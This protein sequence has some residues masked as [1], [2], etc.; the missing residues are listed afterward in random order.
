MARSRKPRLADDDDDEKTVEIEDDDNEPVRV[1]IVEKGEPPTRGMR[2]LG[3]VRGYVLLFAGVG[4]VVYSL[5][6]TVKPAPLTLGGALIGLNPL[7]KVAA[8]GGGHHE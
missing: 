1:Q 6:G 7:L 8:S 3:L 2:I 5:V 4:L